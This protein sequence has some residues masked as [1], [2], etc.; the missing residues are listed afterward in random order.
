MNH[1]SKQPKR[2]AE[3][4][5]LTLICVFMLYGVAFGKTILREVYQSIQEKRNYEALRLLSEYKP[6]EKELPLYFYLKGRALAGLGKYREAIDYLNRAYIMAKDRTLKEEALFERG[7]TYLLNGFYYEAASN[8]KTFIELYPQSDLIN[9]AYIYYAQASLKTENYVKALA[10]FRKAPQNRPEVIFGKAEVFQ[11]LG[12]LKAANELYSKGFIEHKAYL[13]NHPHIL[14]YYA[15]NLRLLGKYASAKTLYY[16][17]IESPLKDKAYLGLGLIEFNRGNIKSAISYL[18]KAANSPDRVARRQGLLFLAKALKKNGDKEKAKKTF[19]IIRE[20]FPYT[21]EAEEAVLNLSVLNREEGNYLQSAK[22]LKE[23]LFGRPPSAE[24][25][26]ELERLV[27]ESM[28]KD[29]NSFEKIWKECGLWLFS[30][31]R[32]DTLLKVAATFVALGDGDFLKIYNY[33]VKEGSKKA[34]AEAIA[35]LAVFYGGMGDLK[36]VKTLI[37]KLRKL[38]FKGDSYYRAMAWYNYLKGKMKKAYRYI[39]RIRNIQEDDLSLFWK[40]RSGAK[41][42]VSFVKDYKTLCQR[43]E[44]SPDYERIGD[45]FLEKGQYRKAIKYYKLALKVNPENRRLIFKVGL[46]EKSDETLKK[47]T[48]VNDLYSEVANGLLHEEEVKHQLRSM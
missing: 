35:N 14:Y 33:L 26:Y 29:R 42:L 6:S 21:P 22:L 24:A 4:I 32:E 44:K 3:G 12:L 15:E 47:L 11:R 38:P 16:S 23:V 9:E 7:K 19:N 20:T 8:F 1:A 25:L 31:S 46:Y 36:R 45:L 43:A 37:K 5:L 41:S 13:K 2:T 28:K 18:K 10:Y 17:L 34:K 40:V 39:T 27:L 30:S 48:G